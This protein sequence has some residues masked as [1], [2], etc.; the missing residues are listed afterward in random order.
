[1][2]ISPTA[3][4]KLIT[5]VMVVFF[6]FSSFFVFNTVRAIPVEEIGSVPQALQYVAERLG[7]I[8][9]QNIGRK[10]INDFAFDAATYIGAGGSGQKAL[11]V[12]EKWGNFW[13]NVGD[14]AAGD[15]VETFAKTVISDVASMNKKKGCCW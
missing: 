9:F 11:F 5:A 10:V 1:M 14:K 8:F 13:K 15:F 3:K 12:K 2:Q 6:A 7:S 4:T